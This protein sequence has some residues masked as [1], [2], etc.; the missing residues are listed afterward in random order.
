MSC[1]MILS[2]F[3]QLLFRNCKLFVETVLVLFQKKYSQFV[4]SFIYFFCCHHVWMRH[5]C[6]LT[7]ISFKTVLFMFSLFEVFELE[8]NYSCNRN[9]TLWIVFNPPLCHLEA[10]GDYRRLLLKSATLFSVNFS[11]VYD[12]LDKSQDINDFLRY[13]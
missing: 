3:K 4:L 13:F 6:S 11:E 5:S 1:L 8:S 10:E 2:S 12:S 7:R 9:F